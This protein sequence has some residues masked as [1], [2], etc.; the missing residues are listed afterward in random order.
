M[1]QNQG[2]GGGKL[3]LLGVLCLAA[4][5]GAWNYARNTAAEEGVF[6]PYDSYSPEDLQAL[7]SAYD[8]DIEVSQQRY[9]AASANRATAESRGS[10]NG[11]LREFER[12]Q[13]IGRATRKLG[14]DLAEKQIEVKKI[15][16]EIEWRKKLGGELDV[17][18]RRV[19]VYRAAPSS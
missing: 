8:A 10:L 3:L 11:R 9:A 12:V 13:K 1:G 2:G 19:F 5:G 16:E 6:R 18:L 14:A 17:F 4:G 15:R 7:I